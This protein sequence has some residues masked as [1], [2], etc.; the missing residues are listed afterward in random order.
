VLNKLIHNSRNLFILGALLAA[1]AFVLAFSLLSKAQQTTTTMAAPAPTPVPAPALVAKVDVPAFTAVT[2]LKS[3]QQ[4]FK[5]TPVKGPVNPDY[6]KGFSGL[7]ILLAQAPRHLAIALPKGMQLM[8]SS[9][10]TNTVAGAVDFS[11]LLNPGEVAETI[12]IQPVGAD[13]GNIQPSDHVDLLVSYKVHPK[14]S[15][16]T[17]TSGSVPGIDYTTSPPSTQE[18]QTTLENLR[19]LNVAG[20]NYTLAVNHQDAL[21]LKWAKDTNAT[22]DLVVRAAD[23]STR[24]AK[25]FKTTAILPDYLQHDKHMVN[26]FVLP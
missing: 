10:V 13:N 24:K 1:V 15:P 7:Q 14:T 4:Y 17:L 9:L 25:I 12:S 20:T 21:V 2:D 8:S 23:D 16:L 26:P 22:V 11:P 18:T 5:E 19:V 3:A 6:V